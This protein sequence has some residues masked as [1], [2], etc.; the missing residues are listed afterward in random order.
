VS[1]RSALQG[2]RIADFS[3]AWAGPYAAM[4]LGLFGAEVIKIESRK[5][6]DH[7][8]LRA[9]GFGHFRGVDAS[10]FFNDLN[11]NK[12][13]VTLDLSNPRAIEVAK[14]I[15]AVSD[16]ML[17]NMR[18]G[19][20]ERLGLGY[21]AMT[22]VKP[23]IIYLSS[24]ACG[25]AG[26]DREYV[27]Y[28]PTFGALGGGVNLTG[29]P[30]IAPQ[31]LIGSVDLRSAATTAFAILA[32]LVH[33]QRT[34]E[35]QHID[36]SSQE[37]ISVLLGDALMEYA[38][39]GTNRVRRGNGDELMAPHNSYPCGNGRWVTIAVATDEE[40][41]ALAAIVGNGQLQADERFHNACG[42]RRH[43]DEID[44]HLTAWTMR[45]TPREVMEMLQHVGVAAVMSFDSETMADDPH[46]QERGVFRAV[47]HQVIGTR[48]VVDPHWRLSETPAR[49]TR[50]APLLG[51]HNQYVFGEL[52]RMT[53]SEIEALEADRVAY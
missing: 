19:V 51:A 1:E 25:S 47:D 13:S 24:S 45:K 33:R 41:R 18:P 2:V 11:L 6:L 27:G 17:Q 48:V 39:N 36:V 8:R 22:K 29:F 23:D 52:L 49:I 26:P 28:A 50:P 15:V 14:K 16:V 31:P 30:D 38:M 21:E 12:L 53:D 7:V 4:E 3:W 42:R 5:R 37:T 40:W 34:G 43:R 44:G 9:L 20:M 10:P 32:A 46:L 35:G